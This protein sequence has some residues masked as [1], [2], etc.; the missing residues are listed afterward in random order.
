[1]KPVRKTDENRS[2]RR[3]AQTYAKALLR[4]A[5]K[6]RTRPRKIRTFIGIRRPRQRDLPDYD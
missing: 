5:L 4:G 2:G 6:N 1:M 3:Q